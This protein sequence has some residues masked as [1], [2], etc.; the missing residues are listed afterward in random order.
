MPKTKQQKQEVVEKLADKLSKT[1]SVV[2]ANYFGLKVKDIQA[3]KKLC[4]EV[5]VEYTVVKKTLMKLA[6]EKAGLKG[7]DLAKLGGE[8]AVA[9]GYED[10]VAAAK[11]LDKFARDHES[12]KITG[13][14]LENK[15]T[16]ANAMKQLASLP[17]KLELLA[18]VV[19]SIKSPVSGF[20]NVLA[21]NLRGL[22]QVLNSIKANK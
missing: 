15:F 7:V 20:V 21:G 17:S 16:D 8:L 9:L 5:G 3:L 6:L 13:G 10:E 1:K 11:V 19:G 22:V 18:K 4:K 14:I 2:F 12:L